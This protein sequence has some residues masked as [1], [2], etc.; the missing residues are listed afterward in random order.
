[1]AVGT[2]AIQTIDNTV[3]REDLSQQYSMI[4]PEEVPFQT[5]IGTAEAPTQPYHEWTN[6][7]LAAVDRQNRVVEGERT[8]DVDAGTLATRIGNYCQISDKLV[9]VTHTSENSEAA[10]ENIQRS[11]KQIALKMREMKRDMEDMLL[12][13]CAAVPSGD[14]VVRVTAG[15]PAFLRT[16]V[17]SVA[18]GSDPTLS[19]GTSGYPNAFAGEGTTPIA[20]NESDFNDAIQ[21]AWTNGGNPTIAMMTASNKRLVSETFNGISTQ[22]KDAAQR[23][24]INAIDIYDSDFG[25]LSIVPNRFQPALNADTTTAGNGLGDNDNQYIALLDPDFAGV[26]FY[27]GMKQ[28]PLAETGHAKSRLVWCEYCLVVDNEAAHAIIR[29][30]TGSA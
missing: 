4:S 19:G 15:L 18:G 1:M 3:L 11:A 14:N 9:E 30:T 29:D 16:N 20:F 28:K 6:V 21:Q 12:T 24:L 10:A 7:S 23:S 17:K 2:N 8:P 5:A 26:A 22:Y 27:E 25:K 13:N